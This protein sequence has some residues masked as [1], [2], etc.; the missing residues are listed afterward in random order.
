MA[1]CF[2]KRRVGAGVEKQVVGFDPETVI[3]RLDIEVLFVHLAVELSAGFVAQPVFAPMLV[4]IGLFEPYIAV[5]AL[6]EKAELEQ[7]LVAAV[8][9]QEVHEDLIVHLCL[10]EGSEFFAKQ[11]IGCGVDAGFGIGGMD[12]TRAVGNIGYLLMLQSPAG[13]CGEF[14]TVKPHRFG[15]D[16]PVVGEYT[17]INHY[18][19]L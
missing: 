18:K 2:D 6:A 3:E 9:A 13:Q 4:T 17:F 10:Q 14:G 16:A 1:D 12:I 11:V 5:G 19:I 7:L 15:N 8:V